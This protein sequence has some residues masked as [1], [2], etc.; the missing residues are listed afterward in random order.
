L[1]PFA[2]LLKLFLALARDTSGLFANRKHSKL[3]LVYVGFL[4]AN[5]TILGTRPRIPQIAISC[6][7]YAIGFSVCVAGRHDGEMA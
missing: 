3:E 7:E 6:P 2:A 1:L 4:G 5:I